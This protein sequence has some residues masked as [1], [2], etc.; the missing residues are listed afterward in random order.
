M[1][2]NRKQQAAHIP[3]RVRAYGRAR[4]EIA[5]RALNRQDWD[6]L[7]K[8]PQQPFP[9]VWGEHWKQC[10][11]YKVDDFAAEVGFFIDVLGLPVNAFNADYAMFTSPKHDFYFAVV[12]AASGEPSTPPG[13]LRL[14]FMVADLFATVEELQ[15]RGIQPDQPP[16]PLFEGSQQWV[17]SFRTPHG[18]C[19][20]IW[21]LVEAPVS[22]PATS[23]MQDAEVFETESWQET[24][25]SPAS[26]AL[27]EQALHVDEENLEVSH[28]QLGEAGSS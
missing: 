3:A 7:W 27:L 2:S 25:V 5:Q 9:F 17:A 23:L 28:L 16:Q 24:A 26:A 11:E 1:F 19:L 8:P 18:I 13:A 4:I 14:Q 20:E 12:G 22:E 6:A 21:G 10:V 15:L